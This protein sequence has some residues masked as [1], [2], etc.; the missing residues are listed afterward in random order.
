MRDVRGRGTPARLSAGFRSTAVPLTM[1]I[2]TIL[3]TCPCNWRRMRSPLEST[4]QPCPARINNRLPTTTNAIEW[5]LNAGL[6][7]RVHSKSGQASVRALQQGELIQALSFDVGWCAI[8]STAEHIFRRLWSIE[9]VFR[10][11]GVAGA[12]ERELTVPCWEE[13]QAEIEFLT[14]ARGARSTQLKLK[15]GTILGQ[16]LTYITR[17]Q[18]K[19]AVKSMRG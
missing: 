13:G 2:R 10:N 14:G 7:Y 16:S 3:L 4:L 5:L 8:K 12:G 6:L 18:P 1:H 11:F 17:Y 9:G 19:C 15:Q